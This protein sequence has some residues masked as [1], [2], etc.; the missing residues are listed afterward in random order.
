[1]LEG[2][3]MLDVWRHT[4]VRLRRERIFFHALIAVVVFIVIVVIVPASLALEIAW[5]FMLMGLPIL[6][7]VSCDK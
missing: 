1:M 7:R 3:V 5:T 6:C 4:R 2:I